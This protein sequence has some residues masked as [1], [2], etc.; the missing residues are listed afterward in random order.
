MFKLAYGGMEQM[1]PIEVFEQDTS[2]AVMGG[3]LINDMRNDQACA[4]RML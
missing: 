2:N 1:S 3:L 4:L